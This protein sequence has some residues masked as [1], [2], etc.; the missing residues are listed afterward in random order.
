MPTRRA[1]HRCPSVTANSRY[2]CR[3]N[4]DGTTTLGNPS[5]RLAIVGALTWQLDRDQQL[6]VNGNYARSKFT[7]A[8]LPTQKFPA[9]PR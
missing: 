5:E 9:R 3:W 6:F 2:T 1:H 8:A 4:G 7:F